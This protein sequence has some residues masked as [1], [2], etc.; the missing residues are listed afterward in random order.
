MSTGIGARLVAA[1][2]TDW[3]FLARPNQVPPS[4]DYSLWILLAGRGFGKGRS[5]TEEV[6]AQCRKHPGS[7]WACIGKREIDCHTINAIGDSGFMTCALPSDGCSY[8]KTPGSRSITMANGSKILFFSSESPD[9]IAGQNLDGWMWDEAFLARPDNAEQVLMQL[10]MAT[11][12]PGTRPRGIITSTPRSTTFAKELIAATEANPTG[13]VTRGKTS[14]NA[15]NLSPEFL[16]E[17]HELYPAGSRLAR[18]ELDGE[19][20]L[21][22][23][24]A[25]FSFDDI[26]RARA[27]PV[28][29]AFSRIIVSVDPSGSARGDATGVVAV[30]TARVGGVQV[31]AVLA[32]RAVKGDP[33]TR[34][35]AVVEMVLATGASSI[36]VEGNYGG[37]QSKY[38]VESAW[39]ER[40]RTD[41]AVGSCP[42][43]KLVTAKGDKASRIEPVAALMTR[44]QVAHVEGLEHLE[45][46]ATSWVPD[47]GNSPNMLDAMAHAVA[48]LR[49]AGKQ[50]G[51]ARPIQ[52]SYGR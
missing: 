24:G 47:T 34:N 17:I 29:A 43:V 32:A 35:R 49:G 41:A 18:Q 3:R 40:Q 39:K 25:L 10:R 36:I 8:S 31:F 19:I 50:S 16:E 2:E 46:E 23:E 9:A 42:P 14:D 28:P 33:A 26:A 38:A 11:R 4:P 22:V 45:A 20:L 52:T 6:L 12:R 37:D 7:V 5:G 44:G 51:G 30:G 13:Y 27:T 15:S 21:D 1:L 48:H